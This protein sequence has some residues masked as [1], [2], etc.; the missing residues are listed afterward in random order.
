M[1]PTVQ[2]VRVRLARGAVPSDLARHVVTL[3]GSGDRIATRHTAALL[4]QRIRNGLSLEPFTLDATSASARLHRE[5][6]AMV[7]EPL[8]A[9]V[10]DEVLL[11]LASRPSTA[12]EYMGR[13]RIPLAVH[14]PADRSEMET[15]DI[16]GGRR[17]YLFRHLRGEVDPRLSRMRTQFAEF[18]RW[19]Q[20]DGARTVLSLSGGGFRLFATTPALKVIEALLGGDRTRVSE[21]W[22]CS[23]GAFAG[24]VFAAGHRLSLLDEFGYDLYNGRLPHL[25]SGSLGSLVRGAWRAEKSR[26]R[27]QPV[28]AEMVEWLTELDQR[29]PREQRGPAIPFY[30]LATSTRRGGP[31]A[32]AAPHHCDPLHASFQVPCDPWLGVAASTAVPFL[33]RTVRGIG[34]DPREHWIDGS[35]SDETPLY[36]PFLKWQREREQRPDETPDRLKILLVHLNL[37]SSESGVVTALSRFR[38]TRS[39]LV[40]AARLVDTVL[41][42][43]TSMVIDMLGSHPQVDILCAKLSLGWLGLHRPIDIPRAIRTGRT[44]ESWSFTRHGAG[45]VAEGSP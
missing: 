8:P 43:K 20:D 32:L 42:S 4:E 45:A 18:E 35:V 44:V 17:C 6:A 11:R 15:I 34:P 29:E 5:W 14:L 37:R 31:F 41:D 22:G 24:Y 25:V 21:V 7:S 19:L 33:V 9:N 38:P 23:G 40:H 12:L 36:L 2:A 13:G 1:N 26:L 27:G 39:T 10:L 28:L 16:A 3:P 30:A